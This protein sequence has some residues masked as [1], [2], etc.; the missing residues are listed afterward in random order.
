MQL[1]PEPQAMFLFGNRVFV[2]V[3]NQGSQSE[4]ILDTGWGLYPTI[5]V[6]I[7]GKDTE[8]SREEGR[9]KTEVETGVGKEG[10]SPTIDFLIL[11][12][13]PLELLKYT[14]IV[15]HPIY[16]TSLSQP[17]GSNSR[18]GPI[19]ESEIIPSQSRIL[20]GDFLPLVI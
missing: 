3:F 16:N 13:W 17:W 2:D 15:S 10:V 14:S 9:V 5:C 6:F 7:R 20:S 8:I 4:I 12:F 1:P 18:L 11:D 19:N